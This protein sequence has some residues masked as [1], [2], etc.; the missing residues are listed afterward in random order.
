[1]KSIVALV[2][3]S[4]LLS[5]GIT[6][7]ARTPDGKTPSEETV[8]DGEVGA[9]YGLCNAYCEAM[10]CDSYEP[11]ASEKACNKVL[12]NYEKKTGE[13]PPCVDL[14]ADVICPEGESCLD[15]ECMCGDEPTCASGEVCE[16]GECTPEDPC[17]EL[18]AVA[19]CPCNY[20]DVPMTESCW[21]PDIPPG[22]GPCLIG[23]CLELDFDSCTLTTVLQGAARGILA[24]NFPSDFS[25]TV[26][27]LSSESCMGPEGMQVSDLSEAQFLTC[28]C[29][30]GQYANELEGVAGIDISNGDPPFSCSTCGN[31]VVNPLE[32]CDDGNTVS[33]D[34]CS[35][36][37]STVEDGYICPI[38]G[39]LCIQTV[40][41]DGITDPGEQCDDGN[42]EPNDG[43]SPNCLLE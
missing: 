33:G 2:L 17:A 13:L 23:S 22:F 5:L 36:D 41:G 28:L 12:A 8:C 43:C 31:G 38:P 18:A 21:N 15:G 1:M 37:C 9:A 24:Q 35:A 40:C 20:F 27:D 34:G 19:E 11:K 16:E 3:F 30:I 42:S 25:C 10:D 29:R 7:H 6:S 32:S 26:H 39:E 14:C 4:L